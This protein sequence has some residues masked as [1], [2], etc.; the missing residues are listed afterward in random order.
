MQLHQA[1]VRYWCC[2]DNFKVDIFIGCTLNPQ[3]NPYM[4]NNLK[5]N[6]LNCFNVSA[7]DFNYHINLLIID[8][9]NY[10]ALLLNT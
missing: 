6:C 4:P 9:V 3:K 1:M 7:L 2:S 8:G 5:N 10:K